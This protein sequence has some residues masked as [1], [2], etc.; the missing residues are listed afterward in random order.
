[1]RGYFGS[2]VPMKILC[3]VFACGVL[4]LG[5]AIS[6]SAAWADDE[7]NA[8]DIANKFSNASQNKT[9][10]EGAG[11]VIGFDGPGASSVEGEKRRDVLRKIEAIKKKA[12]AAWKKERSP[13]PEV[14]PTKVKTIKIGKDADSDAREAERKLK[15]EAERQAKAEARARA[16][17]RRKAALEAQKRKE[18]EQERKLRE[19]RKFAE[20]LKAEAAAKKKR[21]EAAARREAQEAENR[22]KEELARKRMRAEEKRRA[23]RAHRQA[24]RQRQADAKRRAERAERERERARMSEEERLAR[25]EEQ[26]RIGEENRL[27]DELDARARQREANELR[28]RAEEQR[29]L[30]ARRSQD[31]GRIAEEEERRKRG[32]SPDGQWSN[33]PYAPGSR[34]QR[35]AEDRELSRRM[36]RARQSRQGRDLPSQRH[37]PK[38]DPLG[39]FGRGGDWASPRQRVPLTTKAAVLLIMEI[40]NTGLRSWSKTADPMLCLEDRCYLSAGNDRPARLLKRSQAFGPSVALITRGMACRS[41]PACIFRDIEFGG[42]EALMQ[43][44]DLRFLRHD[45]REKRLVRIDP[46]CRVIRRRLSCGTLVRGTGWRAWIVPENV[47][48][49]A[50]PQALKRALDSGLKVTH[51]ASVN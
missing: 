15:A 31:W 27:A 10:R 11:K 9:D 20:E 41:K 29:A 45:R 25:Q 38:T 42:F 2:F 19:A 46:S 18:A 24:E 5:L 32:V 26:R 6:S 21:A 33:D 17:E 36:R 4:S 22:R 50:G 44:V 40:G 39:K 30:E 23:E 1:M 43:P 7:Q 8:H 13:A 48:K 12:D 3:N 14:Q 49:D 51:S 28:R 47:A 34:A 16:E 37:G 35:E